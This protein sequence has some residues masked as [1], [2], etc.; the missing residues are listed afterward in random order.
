MHLADPLTH[1][2]RMHSRMFWLCLGFFLLLT[3]CII[4]TQVSFSSPGCPLYLL[5]ATAAIFVCF[6]WM[7]LPCRCGRSPL[8]T[9]KARAQ[10]AKHNSARNQ[11][12]ILVLII[13]LALPLV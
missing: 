5:L 7:V 1:K 9:A 6:G 13:A 10:I 4:A 12:G 8:L 3:G 2:L 11:V